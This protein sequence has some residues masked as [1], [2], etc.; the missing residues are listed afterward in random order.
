MS[1]SSVQWNLRRWYMRFLFQQCDIFPFPRCFAN[2]ANDAIVFCFLRSW[3]IFWRICHTTSLYYYTKYNNTKAISVYLYNENIVE[4]IANCNRSNL[5]SFQHTHTSMFVYVSESVCVL[6]N[7]RMN[8][9]ENNTEEQEWDENKA[10]ESTDHVC[11]FERGHYIY[12]SY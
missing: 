2:N 1:S 8:A 9:N 4:F 6:E 7:G 10:E 5:T 12:N 11:V 3:Y